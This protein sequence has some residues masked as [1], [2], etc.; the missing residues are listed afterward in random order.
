VEGLEHMQ[1]GGTAWG[2]ELCCSAAGVQ[3]VAGKA[4][5]GQ[6]CGALAADMS[7]ARLE[8]HLL[9][10]RAMSLCLYVSMS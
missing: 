9:E 10:D 6:A 7:Q 3:W 8:W 4:V 2:G 5:A 1:Q